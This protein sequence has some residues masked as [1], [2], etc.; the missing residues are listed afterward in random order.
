MAHQ[1]Q[2]LKQLPYDG[3]S[4]WSQLKEFTPFSREKMRQLSAEGLAPPVIRMG[5]RCSF[6]SNK[7]MHRFLADPLSYR[8]EAAK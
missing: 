8:A 6:R 1:S 5:I 7:E 2:T 4:R 3:M